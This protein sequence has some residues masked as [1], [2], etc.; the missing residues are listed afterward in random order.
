[1]R[2][3]FFNSCSQICWRSL[4]VSDRQRQKELFTFSTTWLLVPRTNCAVRWYKPKICVWFLWC[5]CSAVSRASLTV[6]CTY[7]RHVEVSSGT[8]GRGKGS[9]F[10]S[11]L[12]VMHVTIYPAGLWKCFFKVMEEKNFLKLSKKIFFQLMFNHNNQN[13]AE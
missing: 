2:F 3:L 5:C 10:W 11:S 8:G 7:H 13:K 12:T 9:H 1:M 4:A 6:C